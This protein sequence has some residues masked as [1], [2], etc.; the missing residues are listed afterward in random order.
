A[1]VGLQVDDIIQ[2]G[3]DAEIRVGNALPLRSM[4]S[5]TVVHN[6]ALRV[7]RGAQRVRSAGASAQRMA[8]ED[9]YC[10]LRL[11]SGEMRRVPADCMATVGQGSNAAHALINMGKA[12]RS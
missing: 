5:G 12:G 8:K 4:P 3:P 1:P 2:A 9:K 11:P 10:L 7:G 6:V